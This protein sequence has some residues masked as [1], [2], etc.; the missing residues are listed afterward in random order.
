MAAARRPPGSGATKAVTRCVELACLILAAAPSSRLTAQSDT[1]TAEYVA[2]GVHVIQR[3]NRATD[4]VA[5]RLYLLGGSR[6]LTKE[7]AGIE[8]LLLHASAY[9]TEHYPGEEAHRAIARTGSR[10]TLDTDVDW[11]VFGFTGLAPDFDAAW[12]VF[13]DRIMHPS[14]TPS[15]ITQARAK[16]LTRA[17]ARYSDPDQRIHVI[18]INSLFAD[19]PYSIDPDGTEISL[20]SISSQQL[21]S[22]AREQIVTSRML[23]V[24][25]GNLE[26]AHAESLVAASLGQLPGGQYRWTLPPPVPERP[27]RWL[28]DH[29]LIPTNYMLGYFAGPPA[30][31]RSY[32]SFRVATALL[33]SRIAYNV[34]IRRS[35]SYAAYAPFIDR[36]IPVGGAYAST[37]RP[38]Q[39][40]PLI[41]DAIRTLQQ[42]EIDPYNLNR[43]L[44]GYTFDYLAANATA[45]DQADFL[46]RAELYLGGYERG[47]EFVK[48]MRSVT[49]RDIQLAAGSYLSK[50]QYAYLGDTTRMRG[51]W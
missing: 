51:R 31:E 32:W 33:S 4:I 16:L 49:P 41:V 45:A 13:S 7:N 47:D 2:A 38:D 34:R 10:L 30:T 14:L 27:T 11:S 35:L 25:V 18:A 8:A 15:G 21:Q 26:R 40:L 29:R 3:I 6:Q 22:Y 39:V 50:I 42:Y 46:A 1:L 12:N 23:L 36:A 19:H 48:R 24:I 37:P 17:H 28:I 43:F 44:D 5:V 9:G 20:S